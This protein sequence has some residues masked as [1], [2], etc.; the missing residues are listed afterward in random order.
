MNNNNEQ[1][2]DNDNENRDRDEIRNDCIEMID[3]L[4]RDILTQSRRIHDLYRDIW[5]KNDF[6]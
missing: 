2:I 4:E 1:N 3:D 6:T 5:G